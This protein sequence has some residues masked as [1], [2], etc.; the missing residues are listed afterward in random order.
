MLILVDDFSHLPITRAVQDKSDIPK[1]LQEMILNFESMIGY[2]VR[3]L[4]TN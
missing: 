3:N 4:W 2:H 1:T